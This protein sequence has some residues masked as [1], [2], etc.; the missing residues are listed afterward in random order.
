MSTTNSLNYCPYC[1]TKIISD[2]NFCSEC[3]YQIEK[4]RQLINESQNQTTDNQINENNNNQQIYTDE[5]NPY[6]QENNNNQQPTEYADTLENNQVIEDKNPQND[7]INDIELVRPNYNENNHINQDNNQ[8][9]KCVE[10]ETIQIQVEDDDS[11]D[12][13]I[14]RPNSQKNDKKLPKDFSILNLND[15]NQ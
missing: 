6:Y 10:S 15:K 1:G 5:D 12:F 14:I 4:L 7:S 2:A 13:D 11:N 9:E 8:D 3:G